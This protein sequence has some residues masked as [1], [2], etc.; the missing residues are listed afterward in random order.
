MKYRIVHI[1]RYSG[2]EPISVGHN[3]AWLTPRESA[4]QKCLNHTLEIRPEP[5]I[6]SQR[7]DYF[8]NTVTQFSFN[9]GYRALTVTAVNE[10]DL[11]IPTRPTTV[12][13]AEMVPRHLWEYPL[14][15]QT[16]LRL[17]LRLF[18]RPNT[19]VIDVPYHLAANGARKARH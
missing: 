13:L 7:T 1:T 15:N 12:V 17:K 9:Q 6:T 4:S 18:W 5:S 3:E 11:H 16:A 2:T 10:V 8:G 14:H 19:V